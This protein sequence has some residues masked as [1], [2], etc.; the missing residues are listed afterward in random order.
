MCYE[1]YP[2]FHTFWGPERWSD[3]LSISQHP[4]SWLPPAR[5]SHRQPERGIWSEREKDEEVEPR[6][7]KEWK[8]LTNWMLPGTTKP[9]WNYVDICNVYICAR[10]KIAAKSPHWVMKIRLSSLPSPLHRHTSRDEPGLQNCRR[11]SDLSIL[12]IALNLAIS[13]ITTIQ[14]QL[15]TLVI[16]PSLR[17]LS[18]VR[19]PF[20]F[21]VKL[22]IKLSPT[23]TQTPILNAGAI[24][25]VWCTALGHNFP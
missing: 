14:A 18:K 17:K 15:A 21:S 11:N 25:L 9:L 5:E 24:T 10:K 7:K 3:Q 6:E 4:C 8:E 22:P 2:R 16:L 19:Y 1:R 13:W 23:L 20:T 12:E